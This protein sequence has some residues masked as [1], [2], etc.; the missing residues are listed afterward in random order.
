MNL[1]FN[2]KLTLFAAGILIIHKNPQ[3]MPEEDYDL[4]IAREFDGSSIEELAR[5]YPNDALV[6]FLAIYQRKTNTQ[7]VINK[8]KKRSIW[9]SILRDISS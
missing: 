9:K 3:K 4:Q 7:I 6:N 5:Q 2:L 1:T 8:I